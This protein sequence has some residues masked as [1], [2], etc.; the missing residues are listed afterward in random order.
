MFAGYAEPPTV[1]RVD[2]RA[3]GGHARGERASAETGQ[4]DA[5]ASRNRRFAARSVSTP[6]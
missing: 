2:R 3:A 5:A 1:S 4:A 6:M